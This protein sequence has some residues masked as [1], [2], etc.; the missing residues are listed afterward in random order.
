MAEKLTEIT[1]QYHTFVDNQV[2]TKDQLNGFIDYFEDQ[3]RL[4]RV[5]LH[6]VGI[7]CGFK[8]RFDSSGKTV[9]ITQGVGVTTDGDLILLRKNIPESPEKSIDLK[10]IKFTHFRKFEDNF[11]NYRFFRRKEEGSE[12]ETLMDLWEILPGQTG[13]EDPLEDLPDLENKVVLLYIE[14]Y[15]K[16]GDLC[17]T[18]DCDNQGVEQ[19]AR[20]RVL[21]VS[22]EDAE[23]IAGN[24]SLFTK[25]DMAG[26]YF[27][28]PDAA[29]RRVVLNPGNSKDYQNLK[30]AFH[31]AMND[32]TL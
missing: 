19:V 21:L 1:T 4:S 29:V 24:D 7:V 2:L 23:Y 20:L 12:T 32:N 5:F 15:A 3:H 16:E 17:T 22:K 8:L 28:L 14:A 26:K 27:D 13:E 11:A 30:L 31:Q 18:V 6:G 25:F 10:E 9:T